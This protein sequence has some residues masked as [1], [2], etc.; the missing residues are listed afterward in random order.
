MLCSPRSLNWPQN[1]EKGS[2]EG[3]SEGPAAAAPPSARPLESMLLPF[4]D[5]YPE[6]EQNDTSAEGLAKEQNMSRA[7]SCKYAPMLR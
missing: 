1:A 6:L 5:L 7:P 2:S 4:K 3:S